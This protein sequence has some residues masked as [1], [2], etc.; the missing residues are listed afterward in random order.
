[1]HQI[2]M[3]VRGSIINNMY[4]YYYYYLYY[5]AKYY[6]TAYS[7]DCEKEVQQ[8]YCQNLFYMN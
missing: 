3:F 7:R 6:R 1:M 4:Y 5:E 2:V 8:Y